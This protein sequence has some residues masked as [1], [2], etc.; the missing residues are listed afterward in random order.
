MAHIVTPIVLA[1]VVAVVVI[2]VAMTSPGSHRRNVRQVLQDVRDGFRSPVRAISVGILAGTRRELVEAAEAE[3][4]V[5]DLFTI[6]EVSGP[7]YVEPVELTGPLA[8]PLVGM[9]RTL[10]RV[11]PHQVPPVRVIRDRVVRRARAVRVGP[12][13][14]GPSRGGP[15]RILPDRRAGGT[16]GARSQA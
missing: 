15:G 1:L 6:G 10:R 8:G 13:Q 16:T 4:T 11:V 12:A 9:G 2:V 3:G 5:D 7:A 14:V